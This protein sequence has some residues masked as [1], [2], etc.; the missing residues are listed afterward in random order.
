MF[1]RFE[2]MNIY[3]TSVHCKHLVA[4]SI[5]CLNGIWEMFRG[6]VN[7]QRSTL[8]VRPRPPHPHSVIA[9]HSV[10]CLL[11]NDEWRD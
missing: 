5:M 7:S 1:P 11:S 9:I 2:N 4:G 6:E 10:Y 8:Q 3:L